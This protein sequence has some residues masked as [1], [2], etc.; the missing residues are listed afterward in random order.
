MKKIIKILF[1]ITF[2]LAI[3]TMQ[4]FATNIDNN[5]SIS[6][7]DED[8]LFDV[9]NQTY[10]EKSSAIRIEINS[11]TT[12]IKDL[13]E[14][15]ANVNDKLKVLNEKYKIDKSI[16]SNDD[17]KQI[18]ELSK[19]IK[20]VDKTEKTITEENS[21]KALVQN[22]EYDKAL[23]KLNE[24]LLNKKVQLKNLQEENV[25]WRQINDLIE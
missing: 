24:I 12:Q 21:I 9:N 20:A 15:N 23:E 13:R 16:I 7:Y 5:N 14:Y 8:L 1:A 2:I 18:K 22:K 4:A 19:L 10:I 3:G 6:K 17:M 25:I 11:L